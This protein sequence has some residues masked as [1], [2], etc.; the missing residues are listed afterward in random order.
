MAGYEGREE[1]LEIV[2]TNQ[3]VAGCLH[4][5]QSKASFPD[6]EVQHRRRRVDI[7]FVHLST[8]GDVRR[9]QRSSSRSP[10]NFAANKGLA[11][12][13]GPLGYA[14]SDLGGL[15]GPHRSN[16]PVIRR[17]CGPTRSFRRLLIGPNISPNGF[18]VCGVLKNTI[19]LSR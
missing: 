17:I 14:P 11:S 1:T 10:L 2:R 19:Y 4:P 6:P 5:H 9:T 16:L 12:Q 3:T 15:S 13:P 18:A 8:D 7:G